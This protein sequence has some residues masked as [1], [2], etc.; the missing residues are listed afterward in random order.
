[1]Q[2]P[3]WTR[4]Y[5]KLA[6]GDT[7]IFDEVSRFARNSQEGFAA[8]EELYNRGV[9][10]IFLKEPGINSDVYRSAAQRRI[11]AAN[12]ATGNNAVDTFTAALF[13]AINQLLMDLAKQ[14]I[15]AAF[16][17]AQAEVDHLHQRTA[18]GVRKAI[19]RYDREE[20]EG[21]PHTKGRPGRANTPTVTTKKSIAAKEVIRKHNKDFGGS[22]N[23]IDT[24][25]MIGQIARNS[26]YRYKAQLKAELAAQA[27]DSA[28]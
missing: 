25:K 15:E 24:M 20:L 6:Q 17:Q 14:Q 12:I 3:A 28:E 16:A 22:L 9:T 2:R 23:D 18:E 7:V 27:Q 11:E 4:L 19:E 21:K 10:L 26:F 8:Y 1:M 5:N 13:D